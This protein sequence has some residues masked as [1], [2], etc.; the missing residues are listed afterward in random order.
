MGE[1]INGRSKIRIQMPSWDSAQYLKFTS[2]RTRPA[3]DLVARIGL[4]APRRVVDLGCGPG[5]STEVLR[6]RWP[7]AEIWGIDNSTAMIDTA[8]MSDR[9][10]HWQTG[11][12]ATW[13]AGFACNV[14]FSNAAL[15]WVPNHAVVLPQLFAQLEKEGALAFQ[16]PANIDAPA[17]RLMRELALSPRWRPFF[18]SLVREWHVESA[19]SYHAIFA[20]LTSRVDFW[21]TD[22]LHVLPGPEAIL[23]W[24]RGTGLRPWLE[25]LPDERS[26]H[27][28]ASDYLSAL[29][30]EFPRQADGRVIFPFRRFF[31]IAY[32]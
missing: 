8:Q 23:E 22:Y 14:I 24:Y 4:E 5:N 6:E 7:D 20:P 19:S 26:R 18:P 31:L 30:S 10:T 12:I 1:K 15:Q 29:S 21:Y 3:Q 27:E 25:A 9:K 16:V 13:S 32:R 11:D 28:Y 2:E 17:H